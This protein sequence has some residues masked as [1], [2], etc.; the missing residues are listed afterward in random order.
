M[1]NSVSIKVIKHSEQRYN[2]LGDW[3]IKDTNLLIS[4]SDTGNWVYNMAIGLHELVEAL[5]CH[6]RGIE[7]SVVDSFD[8]EYEKNRSIGDIKEPGDEPTAPYHVEHGLATS[9]E[10]MFI[11]SVGNWREYEDTCNSI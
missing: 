6:Y 5:L 1:I 7:Q 10:R 4:V 3:E 9:V 2:T 8:I 11:A